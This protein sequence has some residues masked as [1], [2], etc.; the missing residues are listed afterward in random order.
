M[1]NPVIQFEIINPV[2]N[3]KKPRYEI[4]R[5]IFRFPVETKYRYY[6]EA[7]QIDKDTG[8]YSYYLLLST[9]KFSEHC[10][11]CEVDMYNNC[12]LHPRGEFKEFIMQECAERGNIDMSKVDATSDYDIWKLE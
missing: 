2:T 6:I 1:C 10:R 3:K 5:N 11:L 12:K 9:I 8:E 7:K 4:E